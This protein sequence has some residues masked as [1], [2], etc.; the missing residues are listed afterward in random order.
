MS[1]EE[2]QSHAREEPQVF[3]VNKE[4]GGKWKFNR[5]DFITTAA[6]ATAVGALAGC[7]PGDQTKSESLQTPAA[8]LPPT[9]SPDQVAQACMNLRAASGIDALAISHDG[10]LLAAASGTQIKLWDLSTKR[11]IAALDGHSIQIQALAM[12]PDQ[13]LLVSGGGDGTIRL[14]S[15]PDGSLI[16]TLPQDSDWVTA[17]SI[18]P[19][20]SY[21]ASANG[22][23]LIK[24]WSLPEGAVAQ[25]FNAH[26]D[27]IEDLLFTPDGLMLLSASRD[28]AIKV[29]SLAEK[30]VVNTLA[31]HTNIVTCLAISPGSSR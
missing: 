17:L 31:G 20:G 4:I 7:S 28:H 1:D 2:D 13:K 15:L 19:D 12:T 26:D 6:T 10:T 11:V 14:W 18:S 8:T 25:D 21:L 3:A 16:K 30:A 9:F 5:R 23:G 24:L 29:W 22:S 27:W